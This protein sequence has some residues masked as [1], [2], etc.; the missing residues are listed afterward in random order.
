MRRLRPDCSDGW[1]GLRRWPL[2]AGGERAPLEA[3]RVLNRRSNCL[4]DLL[5]Q[6]LV[7][8]LDGAGQRRWPGLAVSRAVVGPVGDEPLIPHR[9]FP[10]QHLTCIV[11]G[12]TWCPRGGSYSIYKHIRPGG[13]G[14]LIAGGCVLA[15][16]A[17]STSKCE[18]TL[19]TCW[20]WVR[21][22]GLQPIA[23]RG[24][25]SVGSDASCR[26]RA[27]SPI[28]CR[29]PSPARG[30]AQIAAQLRHQLRIRA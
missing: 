19:L 5:G 4:A 16:S 18:L 26:P 21:P 23:C 2:V 24:R 25:R 12:Q 22:L 29:R 1:L 28:A 8:G 7:V 13:A 17:P 6:A 11:P 3:E 9:S 30:V 27:G 14:D 20:M 10:I 15:P